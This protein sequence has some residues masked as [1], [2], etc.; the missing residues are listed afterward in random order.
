M[1][2]TFPGQRPD[3][4]HS[5]EPENSNANQAGSSSNSQEENSTEQI[6]PRH[7]EPTIYRQR[8][9]QTALLAQ[10]LARTRH[11]EAEYFAEW[12]AWAQASGVSGE[13]RTE[14]VNRLKAW[15]IADQSDEPLCLNG[16]GLTV[17]ERL[18]PEHYAATQTMLYKAIDKDDKDEIFSSRLEA[19]LQEHGDLQNNSNSQREGGVKVAKDIA[20][21][22]NDPLT[23]QFLAEKNLSHLVAFM[24]ADESADA[25]PADEDEDVFVDAVENFNLPHST[26][27][28]RMS[29]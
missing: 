4:F 2:P 20:Y 18:Y 25:S 15:L 22:I 12:N 7:S 19:Y 23:R 1:K 29:G 14:A 8:S 28:P 26:D 13:N 21:E 9:L 16:L 6:K 10:V 27:S 24:N 17:L 5:Q 11:Q 3:Y